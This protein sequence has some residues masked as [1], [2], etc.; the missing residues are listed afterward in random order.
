MEFLEK[1]AALRSKS[2]KKKKI[3]WV[4]NEPKEE[5]P[6]TNSSKLDQTVKPAITRPSQKDDFFDDVLDDEEF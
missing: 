2:Q 4:V 5:V 1:V 6:T 3:N